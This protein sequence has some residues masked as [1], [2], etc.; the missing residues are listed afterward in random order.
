MKQ[1]DFISIHDLTAEEVEETLALAADFKRG[2]ARFRRALE[3]KVLALVFEKPSLRTRVTFE[4]AMLRMGGHSLYLSPADIGVGRRE[5]VADIARNLERLVDGI[6][7]R[8]FAHETVTGLAAWAG[9]PVVNA[10]T[11]RLHP[12]QALADYLTL[13][14]HLGDLRGK[15][16]CYVGDGNN[17]AHSLMLGGP[18]VGMDVTVVTPESYAPQDD[19]VATAK[20]SAAAAG[21]RLVVTTDLAAVDGSDA[22]YTDK[23]A[24]MGQESEAKERKR[25]F[26]PYQVNA[27]LMARA[28]PGAL[29]LHCL[30][31]SRGDEV[32]AE[33]AD[34]PGSVIFDQAENRLT[35]QAAVLYA[36]M[37]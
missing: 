9:I 7:A 32:T 23:W 5:S 19:I 8:T 21:T 36:L 37:T 15:R 14:E 33:V 11:D 1:T 3:G 20:K 28:R 31:A 10:L 13:K 17:V 24:S 27:A 4:V 29:F 34:G 30:P 6:A 26:G 22:V 18:K 2:D 16:L 12:C 25:I 35:T